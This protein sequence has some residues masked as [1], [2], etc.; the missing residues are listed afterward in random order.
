MPLNGPVPA[1]RNSESIL[2]RS[3]LP[4]RT[5]RVWCT[6]LGWGQWAAAA[7]TRI[8]ECHVT[9]Q[10]L[11]LYQAEQARAAHQHVQRMDFL[12]AGD[13]PSQ[14]CSLAAIPLS[15]RGDGELARDWLQAGHHLLEIDGELLASTDN[16]RDHWL[17]HEME[18]LFPQVKVESHPDGVVYRGRKTSRAVKRKNFRAEYWFRD[19]NRLL[20]VVTRPGVFSHRRLD[21]GA[22]ALMEAMVIEPGQRVLDLGCGSGPVALAAACRE[23]GVRVE[24]L[25]SNPRAVACLLEGAALNQL[26]NVAARLDATGASITP[27]AFDVVVANPPYY[28]HGRI[29]AIFLAGA[30]R[31]LRPG[32]RL[33][34]VT[35]DPLPI[36]DAMAREFH[37]IDIEAVRAY[38][39]V[40]GRR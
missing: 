12:C 34:V 3:P 24:A 18:R 28:S 11:D 21:T 16:P 40:N 13:P 7:A 33:W 38:W 36:A 8:A 32:G 1:P 17:R 6:T 25:D 31:A 23:P 29:V 19:R 37:S 9:C 4:E 2:L 5:R 39:V 10:F 30:S 15:T 20:R 35:K 14:A 27:Q 26:E 22:R